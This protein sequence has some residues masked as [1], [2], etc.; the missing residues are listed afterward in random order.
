MLAASP[1]RTDTTASWAVPSKSPADRSAESPARWGFR[2]LGNDDDGAAA[3]AAFAV[4]PNH[5]ENEPSVARPRRASHR[6]GANDR[7]RS[8]FSDHGGC[9]G[10]VTLTEMEGPPSPPSPPE[11]PE[12]GSPLPLPEPPDSRRADAAGGQATGTASAVTSAPAVPAVT[13]ADAARRRGA[14]AAGAAGPA[15]ASVTTGGATVSPG[16]T[17]A[18]VA[19]V[20]TRPAVACISKAAVAVPTVTA[21]PAVASVTAGGAEAGLAVRATC[22]TETALSAGA[23]PPAVAAVTSV[24][25]RLS[26]KIREIGKAVTAQATIT[27][28]PARPAVTAPRR[29]G[30]RK[31]ARITLMCASPI[32]PWRWAVAVAV[33]CGANGSPVSARRCPKAWLRRC[34]G[35]LRAW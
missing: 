16:P 8:G 6:G 33:N 34:V 20:A 14:E 22:G 28:V 2:R 5:A 30:G 26:V 1:A 29:A 31:R 21:V 13:A 12:P 19:A 18:A 9:S 35:R 24:A 17:Q 23:A 25:A 27:S 4:T 32:R 11:P 10:Y 7:K 3:S 15:V